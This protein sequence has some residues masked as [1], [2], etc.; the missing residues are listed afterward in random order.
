MIF[1]LSDDQIKRLHKWKK[2]NKFQYKSGELI[3]YR[4]TPTG[5]GMICV[6]RWGKLKIDLTDTSNW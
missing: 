6:V 3:E 1:K 2:K 4:F 5:V